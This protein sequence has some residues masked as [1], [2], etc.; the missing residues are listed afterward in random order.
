MTLHFWPTPQK[1]LKSLMT[2]ASI[3]DVERFFEKKY[4]PHKVVLFST[5][6]VA[7]QAILSVEGFSKRDTVG[8]P[9]FSS[10]CVLEAVSKVA[11]PSP[12][13]ENSNKAKILYHQMG[14]PYSSSDV[15]I[16]DSADSLCEKADVL[17]LSNSKFEIMSLPKIIGSSFGGLV[18]TSDSSFAEKLK[19]WRD[20]AGS[21]M[22]WCNDLLRSL[23]PASQIFSRLWE[24]TNTLSPS[25][26]RLACGS[27]MT[28]CTEWDAILEQRKK[29]L[30]QAQAKFPVTWKLVEG[31]LPCAWPIALDKVPRFW[32]SKYPELIR[33]FYTDQ[34]L[35]D[36]KLEKFFCL[37]I[38]Q[39]IPQEQW[40]Y[41]FEVAAHE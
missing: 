7:I 12:F 32:A 23:K 8:V 30:I 13:G 6:R 18:V 19:I 31:R 24:S 20:Q 11:I 25:L 9:H 2:S 3:E 4:F 38:H 36:Y 28:V 34:N 33:H 5:A 27:I 39:S 15:L 14:I 17:F 29:M 26:S 16:E 35:H 21:S 37:P 10:T 1:Q 41:F 22:V 40:E